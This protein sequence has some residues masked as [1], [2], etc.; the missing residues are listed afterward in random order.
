MN[1]TTL[2]PLKE[3]ITEKFHKYAGKVNQIALKESVIATITS[4][5][6]KNDL[7]IVS[8]V[9]YEQLLKDAANLQESEY[10]T[11][12]IPDLEN[13]LIRYHGIAC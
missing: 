4:Y 5:F 13:P 10:G 1:N 11:P 9:E 12:W 7:V 3:R 8:R 2:T 6:E